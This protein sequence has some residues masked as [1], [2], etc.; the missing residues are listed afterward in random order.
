MEHKAF[1]HRAQGGILRAIQT[2]VGVFPVS[3][4]P[5]TQKDIT[6]LQAIWD[7][8]ATNTSIA[9]ESAIKLNLPIFSYTQVS[10]GAGIVEKAPVYLVNVLLPNNVIIPNVP[11]TGLTL[12]SCEMLIGMDIITLGDFA[13][14]NHNGNTVCSFRL[15]SNKEIDFIPETEMYNSRL[16]SGVGSS[17]KN[18]PKKKPRKKRQFCYNL[19]MAIK[20][21]RETLNKI[22]LSFDD[23]MKKISSVPSPKKKKQP[24]AA[25]K[26]I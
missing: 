3:P 6:T 18:L 8:G 19:L 16:R 17:R 26:V 9:I 4:S 14:T 2:P 23:A 11:A 21:K 10:T 7:T 25:V 12:N 13:I 22:D 1:T 15:P 20:K 5:A 24:V